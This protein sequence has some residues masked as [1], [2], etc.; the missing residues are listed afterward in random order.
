MKK[1]ALLALVVMMSSSALAVNWV[2]ILVSST[3]NNEKTSVDL[4]S[5]QGY[6]FN[7]YNK[8]K[9][10]VMAWVRR[11]YPTVQKLRDGRSYQ[12]SKELWYVDCNTKK[13][14][15][16]DVATYTKGGAKLVWSGKGY[17]S[18]YS[19]DGWDR[20]IPDSVGDGISQNICLAY[21]VK[22]T[23]NQTN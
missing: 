10:Y 17:V 16:G 1:L 15:I 9:Y 4:D 20:V 8:D 14:K 19:S 5:V 18:T 22:N 21:Q 3:E 13:F 7:G 23:A 2:D 11:E 12:E 6:Y